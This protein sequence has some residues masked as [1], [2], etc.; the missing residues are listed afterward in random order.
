MVVERG[1][2]ASALVRA[3]GEDAGEVVDEADVCLGEPRLVL[4]EVTVA[5]VD[6]SDACARAELGVFVDRL[7]E[8]GFELRRDEVA[9]V[10]PV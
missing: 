5:Q 9:P 3:L 6:P 1:R 7:A 10:I 2:L 8:R 4:D